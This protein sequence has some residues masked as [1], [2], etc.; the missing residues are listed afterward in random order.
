MVRMTVAALAAATLAMMPMSAQAGGCKGC[1]KVAKEGKGF[2]CAKGVAF[3]VEMSSKKL[4]KTVS[5]H[6]VDADKI[7]CPG[8]KKALAE[9]G[10][11]KHCHFAAVDGKSYT[12]QVAYTL[13][14][15]MPT[16]AEL[17]AACP[18]RCEKCKTA[19][20]N[21]SECPHCHVGF[22]GGRMYKTHEDYEAAMAA[23]ATLVKA[24]KAA[25]HCEACAVAM[26]TDGKCKVCKVSYKDGKTTS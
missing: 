6:E 12:S 15:G 9:N 20:K 23:H 1:A 22:V 8:C 26:V 25:K 17:V 18:Q 10:C 21:S 4:Y 13:A 14:K 11:C 16:C 24:A 3:G 19:F 2:C 5:A 7:H